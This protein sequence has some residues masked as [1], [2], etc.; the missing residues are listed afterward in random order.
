MA[1]VIGSLNIG[2]SVQTGKFNKG[3]NQAR[4]GVSKFV[5]GLGSLK[6][7]IV[8][9]G[10][11]LAGAAIVKSLSSIV[12][13]ELAAIDKSSKFADEMGLT[14]AQLKGLELQTGL[15]G[16]KIE[17]LEKGLQ[18]LVR[19]LGEAKT[20][21][22]QGIKGL[23]Q[24]GIAADQITQVSTYDA[25]KLISEGIKN[26]AGAAEKA[27]IAYSLFGKQGLE[28]LTFLN[29]GADA[30]DAA[31][32]EADALGVSFSRMDG[33][34]IELANDALLKMKQIWKGIKQQITITIAPL[35]TA[36]ADEL[37]RMGKDGLLAGDRVSS[38]METAANAAGFLGDVMVGL[39][40][41]WIS[42]SE[43]GAAALGWFI[44]GW[45][46]VIN[47]LK[48]VI[49]ALYGVEIAFSD[50]MVSMG[51]SLLQFV[52]DQKKNFSKTLDAP[53]PSKMVEDFYNNVKRKSAEAKDAM[54]NN[55]RAGAAAVNEEMIN[56]TESS[57]K[58]IEKLQD[59]IDT[60]G[61][62]STEA[63]IYKLQMQGANQEL[64]DQAI[65]LD[66]HIKKLDEQK[67][68]IEEA[69]SAQ[70]KLRDEAKAVWESTLTPMEKYRMEFYRLQN[71]MKKGLI[72]EDTF[73]RAVAMA[74]EGLKSPE[75][76]D[77]EVEKG[78]G[79]SGAVDFNS[80]EARSIVLRSRM[81]GNPANK[82][83][84]NSKDQLAENKKQTKHLEKIAA[85]SPIIYTFG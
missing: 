6:G 20:G 1:G 12:N 64:I 35:I 40:L 41:I 48:P 50:T 9:L 78:G 29:S 44:K 63:E 34:Q 84:K 5:G 83:E 69:A 24:L 85:Q 18:R 7:A 61:M 27:Q 30:M 49:K 38:G 54:A 52:E 3:I 73:Y 75:S 57:L 77:K 14:V 19:R 43:V 67:S 45:G 81:S 58:L 13:A 65:A 74:K 32:A 47:I 39:K 2:M 4:S 82:A 79:L 62:T 80:Q 21:Y 66:N 8:G 11:A 51:N 68:A 10:A 59:Q 71:L 70:Q 36:I 23:E 37:T 15:S 46:H 56:L 16:S 25:L 72:T 53:L 33:R 42:L 17:N 55:A 28:L 22:G 31:T 76:T 60:F 26:T